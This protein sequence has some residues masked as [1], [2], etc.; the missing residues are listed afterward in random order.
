MKR[1]CRENNWRPVQ[2]SD[3]PI[4][5]GHV[6]IKAMGARVSMRA[7]CIKSAGPIGLRVRSTG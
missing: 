3:P 5:M 2:S 6:Y 4:E 7:G 1:E